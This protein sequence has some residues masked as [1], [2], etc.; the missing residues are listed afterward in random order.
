MSFEEK[1]SATPAGGSPR[2]FRHS[3]EL[4]FARFARA[5]M[6]RALAAASLGLVFS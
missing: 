2:H 6:R 1:P 4:D 3:H 5:I